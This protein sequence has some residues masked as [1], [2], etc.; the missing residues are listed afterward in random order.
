MVEYIGDYQNKDI[1]DKYMRE[2][3]FIGYTG[4]YPSLCMGTL[5][6]KIDEEIVKFGYHGGCD[7][8][9]FWTS[10]GHVTEDYNVCTN[11][12]IIDYDM[13][14]DKYKKYAHTIDRIFN[15]EVEYGCCGGCI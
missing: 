7:Y 11:E 15:E 1:H 12:W 3:K 13:L 14:P 5:T 2:V 10:G 9:M 8:P 4:E 6:L